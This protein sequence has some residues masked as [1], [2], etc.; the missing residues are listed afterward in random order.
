MTDIQARD[1]ADPQSQALKPYA[2]P[3][4]TIDQLRAAWLDA[5]FKKSRSEKTR[6]AYADTFDQFRATLQQFSLDLD[7]EETRI[8]LIAQGWAGQRGPNATRE[9]DVAPTT[10]NQRLAIISSFYD[11][12][13]RIRALPGNPIEMV[14]R[15]KVQDYAN[16]EAKEPDEI[17]A[18]LNSIDRHTLGGKRDYA[19]LGIALITGHRVSAIAGMHFG[20][21][22]IK[23]TK[24]GELIIINF[25]R[26]K[27]GEVGRSELNAGTSAAL[28][29]Y[30]HALYGSQL[31]HLAHHTPLW[32]SLSRNHTHGQQ[33][34][35]AA[36]EQ[37]CKRR[38][39][40]SKFHTT[41][42]TFAVGMVKAGASMPE[43]Q[44]KL[45]HKNLNTTGRYL[46]HFQDAKNAYGNKMESMFGIHAYEESE[47]E[48][49]GE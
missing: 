49:E 2:P 37:I 33:L 25:P 13:R 12:A 8:S 39:G 32:V 43:V 36:L 14:E 10:I 47:E 31:G 45:R 16:A 29:D 41:R 7:S 15:A 34:S 27:G 19:L 9:G 17:E 38:L 30:L 48:V 1:D 11:Y 3:T 4:Y 20:S 24:K 40:S 44:A 23:A 26:L 6:R 28:L 42:H 18:I 35:V 21:L 46:Q 5:K 22:T